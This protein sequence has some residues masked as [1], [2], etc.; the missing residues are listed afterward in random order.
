MNRILI[1]EDEP[2]LLAVLCDYFR[3]R[4]DQPVPPRMKKKPWRWHRL[5]SLTAFCRTL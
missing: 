4:G 1:A 5:R 2:R 3:S